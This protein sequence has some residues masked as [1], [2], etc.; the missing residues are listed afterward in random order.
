MRIGTTLPPAAAPIYLRD[1]LS[2]ISGLCHGQQE[3]FRLE[4]ELK[5]YF[6]VR[7]CF[8]VSSGKAA[9]TL[10]LEALKMLHPNKDRV[11][12][13]AYACYSLPSAIVRARLKIEL[14]DMHPETLDFDY[15]Q[16]S[17]LLDPPSTQ[18]KTLNKLN[19]LNKPK[20]LK[21]SLLCIIPVHLFGMPSDIE[22]L[23]SLLGNSE[24]VIVEDAAQAM[25]GE[26]NKK[27]LGTY[28][29]VSFFSLGRGKALSTVE[30]GIILTN[31]HD[32]AR[33]IS[34]LLTHVPG[35]HV[36]ELLKLIT[37]AISLSLLM[38]PSLFWLPKSLPFL[39][40]GAT[41]YD[42]DFKI[43]RMTPF[44]A[45]MTRNWKKKTR[46]FQKIRDVHSKLWSTLIKNLKTHELSAINHSLDADLVRFPVRVDNPSL[47]KTI[48]RQ[49]EQRGLGIMPTYPDTINGIKELKH[50]FMGQEFPVAK[51]YSQEIITFPVHPYVSEKHKTKI[52]SVI[53][54]LTQ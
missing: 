45:G 29:D 41:I 9:L 46:E 50:N 7:H 16:L 24:V 21:D 4:T 33:K 20:Q 1:I 5:D 17:K 26:W 3:L 31:R 42:P 52:A 30:G 18:P 51:E 2:G 53:S 28:G 36:V 25:A 15:N 14:C 6:G 54:D 23:R 37:E 10:I 32:I 47:R 13:P 38:R 27:K 19:Q 43:R 12:I 11:L 39:R 48:I 22:R 49:G 44:Q 8:L 35:Y 34:D 40:I